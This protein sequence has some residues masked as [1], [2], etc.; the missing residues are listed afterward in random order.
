MS[1][2]GEIILRVN[3]LS[4]ILMQHIDDVN[5]RHKLEND[6]IKSELNNIKES[7]ETE[8]SINQR[9]YNDLILMN[10]QTINIISTH[11]EMIKILQSHMQTIQQ[12]IIKI[13]NIITETN[14]KYN[15]IMNTIIIALIIYFAYRT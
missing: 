6:I 12:D 15:Y 5:K 14:K 8:Y 10:Q 11:A 9:N 7:A 1:N 4:D 13:N 2:Y 3:N